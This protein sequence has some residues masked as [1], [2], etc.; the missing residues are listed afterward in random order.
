MRPMP[1]LLATVALAAAL[2]ARAQ[3]PVSAPYSDGMTQ[4][5]AECLRD[6]A[7]KVEAVE[8]DLTKATEY[9]VSS[10][11]ALPVAAEQKRLADLRLQALQQHNLQQCEDRVAQQKKNDAANPARSAPGR[12][13]ENCALQAD[14][15]R[16]LSGYS[17]LGVSG[18]G[19]KPA[20]ALSM[21]A[22]LI[23]DIRVAHNKARP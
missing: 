6:N 14:N 7:A 13:Y 9:L 12:V 15:L 16:A 21:A 20:A 23:L 18:L 3:G 11:C 22:K 10:A 2:P 4:A 8:P 1:A 17:F 5:I 19:P